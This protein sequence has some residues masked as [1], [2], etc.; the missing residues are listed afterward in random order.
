LQIQIFT[1]K[2]EM[3]LLLHKLLQNPACSGKICGT[4]T[5]P[6]TVA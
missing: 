5:V 4:G 3:K 2:M 6:G 1:E